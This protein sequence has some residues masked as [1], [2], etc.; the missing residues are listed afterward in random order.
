MEYRQECGRCH[1]LLSDDA[2]AYI[3]SREC[4]FCANCYRK[5]RFTCPNCSTE[6]VRRPRTGPTGN[7]PPAPARAPPRPTSV[8]RAG[9]GDLT[10][11][12]PLFDAYRQFYEQPSD[13]RAS[14]RFLSHRLDRDES[15]V[16]V[17]EE[18]GR[19]VGFVQMYPLFSSI[20]LGRVYVLNDLFVVPPARR[21]GVG[22]ALLDF[23]R[24]WAEAEKA[25]SL[26]LSTA[27]D[28]PAQRLYESC[29]WTTDR[30]FL[31]YELPL[32]PRP[33]PLGLEPVEY[34]S[35]N[36]DGGSGPPGSSRAPG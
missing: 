16:F 25:H 6:L 36:G 17:A 30:E 35:T 31:Y 15:V 24:R 33:S 3:C 5:V 32:S 21:N 19:P 2:A 22:A 7:A 23:A 13:L 29:G 20:S 27:A 28:N 9:R 8:R 14:T 26:T 4:T 11:V 18:G 10:A 1:A 12:A 34:P